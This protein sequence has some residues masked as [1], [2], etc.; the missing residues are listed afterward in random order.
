MFKI[1]R[2][3]KIVTRYENLY[4]NKPELIQQNTE[5]YISDLQILIKNV[6]SELENAYSI[7]QMICNITANL[8]TKPENIFWEFIRKI[9]DWF[10]DKALYSIE[11]LD[12]CRIDFVRYKLRAE[13]VKIF[14]NKF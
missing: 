11:E 2:F 14:R 4:S 10:Y 12:S 5:Y 3:R 9:V 7:F 1:K 6:N 13:Q 8:S